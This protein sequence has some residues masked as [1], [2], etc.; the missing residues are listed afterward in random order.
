[1]FCTRSAHGTNHIVCEAGD[2][3]AGFAVDTSLPSILRF[4][5][6]TCL[7]NQLDVAQRNTS[8]RY[9]GELITHGEKNKSNNPLPRPC[10]QIG[11][12]F[13]AQIESSDTPHSSFLVE[14]PGRH[15]HA[16]SGMQEF[17][18][19]STLGGNLADIVP[20]RPGRER[21]LRG[22]AHVLP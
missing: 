6:P 21:R 20:P 9:T 1:M 4:S 13:E 11:I 10:H 8:A 17:K 22:P 12:L 7:P 16:I 18:T 3:G 5:S 2:T 15:A 19:K 14:N